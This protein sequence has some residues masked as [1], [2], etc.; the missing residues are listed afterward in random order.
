[1]TSDTNVENVSDSQ[2]S[3]S[4]GPIIEQPSG[5]K[6]DD[7]PYSSLEEDSSIEYLSEKD[8]NEITEF[9][10]KK[11]WESNKQESVEV[12]S[13]DLGKHFDPSIGRSLDKIDQLT[14]LVDDSPS[15]S[16]VAS[17]T[18]GSKGTRLSFRKKDVPSHYVD[19]VQKESISQKYLDWH[20]ITEDTQF[21]ELS[22]ECILF[23]PEETLFKL[24]PTLEDLLIAFGVTRET[25]EYVSTKESPLSERRNNDTLCDLTPFDTMTE[26]FT[27]YQDR[28]AH[29]AE[30]FLCFILDRKVYESV[31][32]NAT[33]CSKIYE[34]FS[35]SNFLQKYLSL[36]HSKDYFLHHRL[37]KL[38]PAVQDL[39]LCQ[40]MFNGKDLTPERAKVLIVKEFNRLFDR[41]ELQELLYFVLSVYGSK[42][43]PFGES[44]ATSYFKD[45]IEDLFHASASDVELSLLNGFLSTFKKIRF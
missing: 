2:D 10:A 30:Y 12:K 18:H 31:P 37:I 41:K 27:C 35:P 23:G 36:V 14:R 45:C 38:I 15:R 44:D 40:I 9:N 28:T 19:L 17:T 6:S 25:L 39:L 7:F 3:S 11:I 21:E 4:E 1:M 24:Y 5:R 22:P 32:C 20:F 8:D 26:L 13:H 42:Y 43:M 29:Y 16:R 34:R 33:W